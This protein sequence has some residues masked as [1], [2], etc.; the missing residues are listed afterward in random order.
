MTLRTAHKRAKRRV[1]TFSRHLGR[2]FHGYSSRQIVRALREY[3]G[4]RYRSRRPEPE[5]DGPVPF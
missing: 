4:P 1:N 2:H 3:S 5:Y